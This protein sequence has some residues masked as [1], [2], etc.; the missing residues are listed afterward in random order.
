[1]NRSADARPVSGA[2]NPQPELLLA[3][4]L[5]S[6]ALGLLNALYLPALARTSPPLY[7]TADVFQFVVV[8]AAAFWLLTVRGGLHPREFGFG[9]MS[10][11]GA[12]PA[13][14]LA[15]VLLVTALYWLSYEPAKAI[16]RALFPTPEAS[17]PF[18]DVLPHSQPW[19]WLTVLYASATAAVVEEAVFRS[20]PWL[21]FSTRLRAPVVPYVLSTALLFALIHSEQ[22]LPAVIAAGVL[23][24]VAATLYTRIRNVWPFVI[25]HF[26]VG[27]WSYPWL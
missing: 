13:R 21:Y 11:D 6:I 22:G 10:A 4:I 24:V 26:M 18:V 25:A 7:W 3:A 17:V 15:I 19:R 27:V 9:R 2:A 16:A 14:V 12:S 23:G 1:M 20:V 8:P 5:P